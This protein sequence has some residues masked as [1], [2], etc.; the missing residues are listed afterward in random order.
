MPS[1]NYLSV[2]CPRCD[3]QWHANLSELDQP[4]NPVYRSGDAATPPPEYRVQ[5]P[6]CA[7]RA[8]IK[9]DIREEA[10]DG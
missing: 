1:E 5:C 9:L 3:H 2:N 6:K 7:T 4:L 8:V 10:D